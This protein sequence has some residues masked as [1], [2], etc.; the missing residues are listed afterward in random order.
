MKKWAEKG[1]EAL[2]PL[3]D[4]C[5]LHAPSS[6]MG[7]SERRPL[8]LVFQASR[9]SIDE[10]AADHTMQATQQRNYDAPHRAL[11]SALSPQRRS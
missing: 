4:T 10:H 5:P 9:S 1:G 11:L 7:L 3:C 6:Q 8:L 2:W